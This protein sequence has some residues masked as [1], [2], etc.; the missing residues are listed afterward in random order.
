MPILSRVPVLVF[1]LMLPALAQMPVTIPLVK[2]S[3]A[4][5]LPRTGEIKLDVVVTEKSDHSQKPVAGLSEEDFVVTD[6]K[7]PSKILSFAAEQGSALSPGA[8]TEIIFVVDQVNTGFQ[9][10]AFERDELKHYFAKD[11]GKLAHPVSL[12]FFSDLGT[13]IQGSPTTDGNSLSAALDA[14]E[15]SLRTLRRSAGF[16]GAEDRTQLSLDTLTRLAAQEKTKPGRK[17]VIWISPGWPLLSGPEV[18]LTRKQSQGVFD[19]VVRLSAALR[20]ARITLYSVDPLG[21]EDAGSLRTTYYEEFVKGITGPR[22]TDIG[23]L[24]LQ[25]IATQSGGQVRYGSNSI[26][27]GIERCTA[28]LDAF[29]TLTIQ[30]PP[31]DHPNE[32]HDVRVMME[33]PKLIARTRTGYYAQP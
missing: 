19:S 21:M 10:V 3:T 4:P 2:P 6:N 17:M 13:Q 18:E 26:V 8:A 12:V 25:T 29:Y 23:D 11:G 27:D 16:Y 31:A 28:D 9:R 30:S 1:C 7:K 14:N 15:N 20:E 5:A 32:Y 33:K 22:K 24:A